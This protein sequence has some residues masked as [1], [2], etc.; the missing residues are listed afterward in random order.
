MVG[1]I[2]VIVV[3]VGNYFYNERLVVNPFNVDIANMN[4]LNPDMNTREKIT[5]EVQRQ[6][7]ERQAELRR[8]EEERLA[9]IEEEKLAKEREQ[10]RLAKIEAEKQAEEERLAKIEIEKQKER[11]L[12]E[13]QRADKGKKQ[14]QEVASSDPTPTRGGSRGNLIGTFEATAYCNC[15][16]CC[17]KWAGGKTASG[18]TPTAGR[19]IAVDPNV[20]PLGS[21]VVV[22]GV[23]YVAEDTGS[24]I[25]GRIID[26]YHRNHSEALSFG[27]QSVEV[28]RR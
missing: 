9:K 22:N 13:K 16:V 27:R 2:L 4:E 28:Y 5:S 25:K 10:A 1:L 20:I 14:G 12:A 18:T 11:E 6:E 7:D 3:A 19:T 23:S 15:S 8:V 24:A 26:I 17:G 21:T